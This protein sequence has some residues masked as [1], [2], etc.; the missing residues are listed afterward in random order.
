[1]SELEYPVRL[2]MIVEYRSLSYDYPYSRIPPEG[3]IATTVAES[4]EGY[5]S[6]F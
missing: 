6:L 5:R 1:M 2:D 4:F 3:D